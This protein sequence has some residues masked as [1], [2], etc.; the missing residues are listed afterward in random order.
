MIDITQR[1]L[2][3]ARTDSK[4]RQPVTI[5]SL[6]QHMHGLLAQSLQ[7]ARI[8][9]TIDLIED[10][11]AVFAAP[12]QIVQVLVNIVVNA[13][14]ALEDGGT[15][16]ITA[17]VEGE[18]V[19][20]TIANNGPSIAPEALAQIFE[21]FFTTRTNGTGLGLF[22]SHNIVQQHGGRLIVENL[23]EGGVAFTLTLPV[24]QGQDQMD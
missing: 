15:I 18:M 1:V 8:G 19:A 20:L 2:N 13:I 24:F 22:V 16:T 5:L 14:D 9:V 23:K 12:D 3:L 21:P 17:A 10:L 7:E 4:V 6:V 11:P